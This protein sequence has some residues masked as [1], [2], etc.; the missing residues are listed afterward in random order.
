M[1]QHLSYY[2]LEVLAEKLNDRLGNARLVESFSQQKDELTFVFKHHH[3][4]AYLRCS[5]RGD[6]PF[7]VLQEEFARKKTNSVNLFTEANQLRIIRF[8][9]ELNDRMLKLYLE[10]DMVIIFKM[11]GTRSNVILIKNNIVISRFR[12]GI[13]EDENFQIPAY[14]KN[15]PINKIEL[16]AKWLELQELPEQKR[17]NVIFPTL[18]R[19]LIQ[20]I[21]N[22]TQ[23][24]L[25]PWDAYS[26]LLDEI[27]N[28]FYYISEDEK[29]EQVGFWIIPPPI[30][31]N[32]KKLEDINEAL[33]Q[34]IRL[35]FTKKQFYT[36]KRR[37]EQILVTH[38]KKYRRQ[39][40]SLLKTLEKLDQERDPEE[41][42]HLIMANLHLIPP[43]AEKI[44][45][46]DMYHQ[47]NI[48]IDLDPLLNPQQNAEKYYRKNKDNKK[49]KSHA[50]HQWVETQE[51]LAPYLE[52][53]KEFLQIS[54]LKDIKF[55]KKKY[56]NLFSGQISTNKATRPLFKE[57]SIDGYQI[58]VG[59]NAQN[60][61]QL[62]FGF[63]GK[64]DTWLHAKDVAGSHVIVRKKGNGH[65]PEYVLE[66]AAGI[67]AY[68]S[69]LRNN[70]L[71][72]VSYTLR[73][74]VRKHKKLAA[75]K[76]IV[77]REETLLIEPIN[78][79]E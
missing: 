62:T 25:H 30:D 53:E 73:K 5:C 32:Y 51:L 17:W 3:E 29:N 64:G 78:P 57:Y 39:C 76:V 1:Q 8:E 63:A 44:D 52:A 58:Y 74:Y 47:N 75:G 22:Q 31:V 50:E 60:N 79:N 14:K 20:Y 70:P 54:T 43:H 27:N 41:I 33:D 26:M 16:E 49:K 67:A 24:G 48:I 59:R 71:V 9:T 72:T 15:V 69:K 66:F 56:E 21:T 6:F 34:F 37:I 11:Y 61:D 2:L 10:K 42:G 55:F 4:T 77:E 68:Y 38:T 46:W 19:F 45:L 40:S 35:Y 12:T 13:E 23:Q 28:K 65:L 7:L 36:E 18:D